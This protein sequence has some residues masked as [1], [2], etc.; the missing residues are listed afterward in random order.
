VNFK[1]GF[2]WVGLFVGMGCTGLLGKIAP[3]IR[4]RAGFW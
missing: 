2:G 1:G 3:S 4:E